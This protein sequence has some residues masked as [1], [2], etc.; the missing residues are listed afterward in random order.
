MKYCISLL[1]TVALLGFAGCAVISNHSHSR[2][3][4]T[5]ISPETI[6]KIAVG[7][8]TKSWLVSALGAPDSA[9]GLEGG[10]LLKYTS[11]RITKKHGHLLFILDSSSE[12][13][14]KETYFFEFKEGLLHRY[15]REE[16]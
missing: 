3:E 5:K 11:S 1:L 13:I 6:S 8:T 15:W 16:V 4:G 14:E 12:R 2:V 9:S 7:E 10:E